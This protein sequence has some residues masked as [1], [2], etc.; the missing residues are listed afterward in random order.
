MDKALASKND[1]LIVLALDWAKAFDSICPNALCLALSRFGINARMT[2]I[3]K[4]IYT[5][6]IFNVK[7]EE[8]SSSYHP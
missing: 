6:R 5:D 4:N 1:A 3:I 7:W 2:A 8:K